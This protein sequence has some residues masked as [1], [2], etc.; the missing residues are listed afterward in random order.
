M[1]EDIKRNES[2]VSSVS[3]RY[4]EAEADQTSPGLFF[5]I[6]SFRPREMAAVCLAY[7]NRK[8]KCRI[9]IYISQNRK[10]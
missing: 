8:T 1:C 3:K 4:T 10:K 9:E 7:L 5:R 2:I 6:M